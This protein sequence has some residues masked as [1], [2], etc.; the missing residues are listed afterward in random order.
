MTDQFAFSRATQLLGW[1]R[2][3]LPKGMGRGF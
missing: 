3:R 1:D 2:S